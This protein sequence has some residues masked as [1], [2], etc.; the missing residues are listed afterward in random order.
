MDDSPTGLI[1]NRV[2]A[3]KIHKTISHINSQVI[4]IIL[5]NNDH[6]NFYLRTIT[7]YSCR[8]EKIFLLFWSGKWMP[9][10]G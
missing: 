2:S 3:I 10:D 4:N 1:Q 5:V 9:K 8:L 6:K 7:L